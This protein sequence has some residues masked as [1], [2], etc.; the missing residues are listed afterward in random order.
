MILKGKVFKYPDNVDT[1]QIIPTPYLNIFVPSLLAPHAMEGIDE[2]FAQKVQPGD[3]IM[4]GENFG[5]GSSREHA[6][7]SIKANGVG[8]VVAK[9]F[10]RIFFRN[11]IN[12]DLPIL[13]CPEAVDDTKAGDEL[14]VNL[15]TRT[16]EN[17]RTKKTYKA[18]S[19]PEYIQE[20]IN[21]GGLMS[22]LKKEAKHG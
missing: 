10:A 1:D 22:Y 9:S 13:E 4:A 2:T 20:I 19:F 12:I 3:I 5:C 14:K 8:C 17:V 16:I 11:A 6:P 18:R 15:K 7:L 21:A